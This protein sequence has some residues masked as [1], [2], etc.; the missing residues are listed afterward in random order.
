[1]ALLSTLILSV[2]IE[3]LGQFEHS[4]RFAWSLSKAK[5]ITLSMLPYFLL[6]CRF[7]G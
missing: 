7:T 3:I 2:E 1:M 4:H 5:V 6:N